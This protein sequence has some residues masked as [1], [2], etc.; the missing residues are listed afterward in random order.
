[1]RAQ[2][3]VD[4][5]RL[6]F[7]G[8]CPLY[9]A[10]RPDRSVIWLGGGGY[11]RLDTTR[12]K[13][14]GPL[15]AQGILTSARGILES[16][17]QEYMLTAYVVNSRLTDWGLG[18]GLQRVN[19]GLLK[20]DR[21]EAEG[22]FLMLHLSSWVPESPGPISL[23]PPRRAA[24]SSEG[25]LFV[26]PGEIPAST[27][28]N[29]LT[30]EPIDV[31]GMTRLGRLPLVDDRP[32]R[33]DCYPEEFVCSVQLDGKRGLTA[34]FDGSIRC[35][36]GDRGD[37]VEV[38]SESLG[39]RIELYTI[40]GYDFDEDCREGLVEAGDL[41]P[42]AVYT[43]LRGFGLDGL[44]RPLVVTRDGDLYVGSDQLRFGCPCEPRN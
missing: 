4:L 10:N 16:E 6:V 43:G 37:F 31:S 13:V 23:G 11:V 26:D 35:V 21:I 19:Q 2:G 36:E 33:N 17:R 44:R 32:I 27:A 20:L 22:G 40:G 24:L 18:L 25:R 7:V 15:A 8:H 39:L 38:E 14:T 30:G 34:L 42:S 1:L 9:V 29:W 5:G 28:V 41:L 12:G 3:L